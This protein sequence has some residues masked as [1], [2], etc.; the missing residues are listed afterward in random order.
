MESSLSQSKQIAELIDARLDTFFP[1]IR[2]AAYKPTF[3]VIIKTLAVEQKRTTSEYCQRFALL[4]MSP[5]FSC[6]FRA[7]GG[8]FHDYKYIVFW[9]SFK[10]RKDWITEANDLRRQVVFTLYHA[11]RHMESEDLVPNFKLIRSGSSHCG[12]LNNGNPVVQ[13]SLRIC[14]QPDPTE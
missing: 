3:A 5:S 1:E 7:C 4:N 9:K 12:L 10:C 2:R 11:D 13:S 14:D 6:R 8:N